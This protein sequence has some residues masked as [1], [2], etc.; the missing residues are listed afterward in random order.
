MGFWKKN[1]KKRKKELEGIKNRVE[2][3]ENFPNENVNNSKLPPS[4]EKDIL[5]KKNDT[6]ILTPDT[7]VKAVPRVSTPESMRVDEDGAPLFI[8]IDKYEGV[9]TKLQELKNS[10][11]TLTRLISFHNEVEELKEDIFS[12]V[13]DNVS[14]ITDILI[15]LDEIFVKPERPDLTDR[16][17]KGGDVEEQ[18]LDLGEELRHLRREL[19]KIE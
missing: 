3:K 7:K 12:R 11:Q 9:V 16:E 5:E 13:K 17:E 6:E 19:N 1:D 10:I 4:I 18:I 2:G 15:T 14:Q 8:K